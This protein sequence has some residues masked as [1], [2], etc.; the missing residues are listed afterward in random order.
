ML[1]LH[2]Y[3]IHVGLNGFIYTVVRWPTDGL[4]YSTDNPL[5]VVYVTCPLRRP[6]ANASSACN[7]SYGAYLIVP[8]L[9]ITKLVLLRY[10]LDTSTR[11]KTAVMRPIYFLELSYT[12]YY[13]LHQ[14]IYSSVSL[15]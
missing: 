3:I 15:F 4:P 1:F 6:H 10:S 5:G 9:Q 8:P 11:D 13:L 14:Q 12:S 7:S 2:K